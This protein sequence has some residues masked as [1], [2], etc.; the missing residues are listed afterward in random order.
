MAQKLTAQSYTT[1]A[2]NNTKNNTKAEDKNKQQLQQNPMTDRK[3]TAYT[4][5]IPSFTTS[6]KK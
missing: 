1:T 3:L 4:N 6:Y 2:A 5:T